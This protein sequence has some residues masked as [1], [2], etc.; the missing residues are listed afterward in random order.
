MA[1]L[2]REQRERCAGQLLDD[3]LVRTNGR[4]TNVVACA[5]T[6]PVAVDAAE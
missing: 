5:L 6:E 1:A 2:E 4:M 3:D